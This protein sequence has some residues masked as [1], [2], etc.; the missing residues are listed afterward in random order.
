M[1]HR[2]TNCA[3][4]TTGPGGGAHERTLTLKTLQGSIRGSL[5]LEFLHTA[6]NLNRSYSCTVVRAAIVHALGVPE[7]AFCRI[8]LL[9]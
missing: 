8:G 1:L 4:A 2:S 5:I 9:R 3:N 7:E 6:V